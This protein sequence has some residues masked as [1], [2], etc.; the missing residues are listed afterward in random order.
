MIDASGL[1]QKLE[2]E[3]GRGDVNGYDERRHGQLGK[4]TNDI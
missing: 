1:E 4:Q 3:V 2:H